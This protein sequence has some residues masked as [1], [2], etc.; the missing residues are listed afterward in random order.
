MRKTLASV[1]LFAFIAAVALS[2]P[3]RMA[4]LTATPSYV[5]IAIQL[6][7]S[8][9]GF[10][11][12]CSGAALSPTVFLT[13]A[14]CF[15]PNEPA[16]VSFQSASPFAGPFTPGE[17][18][19]HPGWCFGC[20]PG[21]QG[22]DTNDVAVI[23]L[24]RAVTLS[25]YAELPDIGLVDTL[26]MKTDVDL[27]GYGVQGFVR[28]GGPPGQVFLAT[29]YFAPSE[30]VHEQQQEQRRIHQAQRQPEQGQGRHLLRRL[31]RARSAGR[32]EHR[33][34]CQLVCDQRQL[35]RRHLLES[36]GSAG[37]PGLHQERAVAALTQRVHARMITASRASLPASA[38]SRRRPA[39]AS[40]CC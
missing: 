10:V 14:H 13:A 8:M 33:P 22:A 12:I 18:S 37:H 23:V 25:N 17:F 16:F 24:S 36:R 34:R 19:R 35:R 5:G 6:I 15:D 31:W 29:R 30:L 11:T 32:H 1:F 38:S 27:V 26:A 28:G 7:P 2:C 9:P 40:T 20:G 3:S 21:L 4:S 39:R